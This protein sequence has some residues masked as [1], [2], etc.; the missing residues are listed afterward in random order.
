MS[1]IRKLQKQN[2]N[3]REQAEMLT[4]AAVAVKFLKKPDLKYCLCN[5]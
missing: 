5:S 1:S 3:D 2:D 4:D